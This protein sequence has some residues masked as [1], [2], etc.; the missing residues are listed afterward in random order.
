MKRHPVFCGLLALHL[1]LTMQQAGIIFS[2]AWGSTLYLAH[3]YNAVK[4]EGMLKRT[5]PDMELIISFHTKER[6][7]V[8]DKPTSV[9]EYMNRLVLTMGISAQAFAPNKRKAKRSPDVP[10]SSKGPRSL[11]ED[12][13]PVAELYRAKLCGETDATD[14]LSLPDVDKILTT[15]SGRTG[16]GAA[17][18]RYWS[19]LQRI[20][21][22][23]PQLRLQFEEAQEQ[24][25]VEVCRKLAEEGP[26][27]APS[28]SPEETPTSEVRREQRRERWSKQ[29]S[30]SPVELLEALFDAVS[31]EV[32]ILK[33]DYF[34][35]HRRCWQLLRRLNEDLDDDFKK[36]LGAEYLERE[37]QLPF[38]VG[39]V[40]QIAVTSQRIAREIRLDVETYSKIISKAS[41]V[42]DGFLASGLGSMEMVHLLYGGGRNLRFDDIEFVQGDEG[43]ELEEGEEIIEFSSYVDAMAVMRGNQLEPVRA[44]AV[45]KDVEEKASPSAM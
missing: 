38:V 24:G 22:G 2:N 15:R 8:G 14:F 31:D 34:A 35:M 44:P 1:N 3:L 26:T 7:F 10:L 33:F 13:T 18:D 11:L 17:F 37:D 21:S 43:L 41:D 30:L 4:Q 39:Y 16:R 12:T 45:Q 9:E 36:Y 32:T 23:N 42:L 20:F 25:Q 5:W 19:V 27:E 28:K 40:F 6:I 29:Q